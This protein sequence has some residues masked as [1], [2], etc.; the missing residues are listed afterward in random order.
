MTREWEIRIRAKH[1]KLGD[2]DIRTYG[3]D[4]LPKVGD[5]FW[6]EPAFSYDRPAKRDAR[7]KVRVIEALEVV[8]YV[9]VVQGRDDRVLPLGIRYWEVSVVPNDRVESKREEP[10]AKRKR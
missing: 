5:T 7:F 2:I 9:P 1:P 8:A 6:I 4:P 3:V 10:Q